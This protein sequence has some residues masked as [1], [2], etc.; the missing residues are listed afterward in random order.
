M[1]VHIPVKAGAK[2]VNESHCT[3]MERGLVL[4]RHTRA[5][6][7]QALR[8]DPQKDAQYYVGKSPVTLHEISQPLGDHLLGHANKT[9]FFSVRANAKRCTT[10]SR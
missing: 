8:Y 4:V 2:P 10:P 6:N 9:D 3:N 7:L 5:V 1:K